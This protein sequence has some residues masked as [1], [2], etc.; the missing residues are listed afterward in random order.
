[1]KVPFMDLKLQYQALKDEIDQNIGMVCATASFVL[2]PQVEQFEQSFTSFLGTNYA[3]GV[4]NA[5]DA[6]YIAFA[7][8]GI[9]PGDEVIL[10]ANTFVATAIA[11]LMCGA[12]PVLVDMEPNTYLIDIKQIESAITSRTRAICPVHL[13]GR[14]CDMDKIMNIA[15]RYSLSVVEDAAQAA[16]ARWQGKRIGT[17]GNAGCFS[18]YPGKN[19]GAFGDAGAIS[20]SSDSLFRKIRKMRNFGSENKYRY[21]EAGINSRLDSVQAAVLN[22][23]LK[24]LD[25]WNRKRWETAKKYC[26]LLS[27]LEKKGLIKLPGMATPEEHVFHLFVIQAEERDKIKERL[28]KNGIQAGIHYPNPFYLESAY[29]QLGYSAGSFPVSEAACKKFLSLP[30]FPEISDAQVNYVAAQLQKIL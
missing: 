10:P 19:L 7:A 29:R 23:K 14:S 26:E 1:M 2:G 17:I 5:T 8:L 20:T 16:G 15:S 18:F 30:M 11:V 25:A 6:L 4:A 9:G 21:P 13:Y 12:R 27:V 22:V 24:Y 3:V 28:A